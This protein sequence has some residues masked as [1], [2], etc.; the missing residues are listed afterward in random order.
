MT[1]RPKLVAAVTLL[2]VFGAGMALGVSVDRLARG[3]PRVARLL[4]TDMSGVLD[5]LGLTP[6]QRQRAEAII[7]RHTPRTEALMTDLAARLGA[8]SDSLDSELRALLTPPQRLRL[9]SLRS[10]K[11]VIFRRKS[12]GPGGTSV[13]DTVF[14][15]RTTPQP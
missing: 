7:E 15:P 2:A 1:R 14:P 3:Q 6:E 12:M 4:R 5:K 8:V 10:T 9:D 11:A 13:V